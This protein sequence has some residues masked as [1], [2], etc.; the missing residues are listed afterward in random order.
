MRYGISLMLA[1]FL[2][3]SCF[4]LVLSTSLEDEQRLS[5]G[6]LLTALKYKIYVVD[7]Y[8]NTP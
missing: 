1:T 7:S 2:W 4:T 3:K 5:V 8:L 6:V